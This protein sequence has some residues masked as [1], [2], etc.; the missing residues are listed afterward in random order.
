[1][2]YAIQQPR[3]L[4][5]R[6][7]TEPPIESREADSSQ[8]TTNSACLISD[9]HCSNWGTHTDEQVFWF[10]SSWSLVALVT[11]LRELNT[12]LSVAL[13][14]RQAVSKLA[15]EGAGR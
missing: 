2:A 10:S 15:Y 4:L 3:C 13:K 8:T 5:E 12:E 1:M 7:N 9:V 11:G 6:K 14:E